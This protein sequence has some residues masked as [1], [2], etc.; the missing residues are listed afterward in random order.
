MSS[1]VSGVEWLAQ[2]KII[3]IIPVQ[4]GDSLDTY[5]QLFVCLLI[6]LLF[7]YLILTHMYTT[8]HDASRRYLMMAQ[9]T[10]A[11]VQ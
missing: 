1:I 8:P 9:Y 7:N 10:Y 5:F 2:C 4:K 11:Y 6:H 3:I